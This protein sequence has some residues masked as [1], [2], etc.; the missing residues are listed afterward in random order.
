MRVS[1]SLFGWQNS[2]IYGSVISYNL[3]WL[4]VINYFLCLGHKERKGYWP[5]QKAHLQ[6]VEGASERDVVNESLVTRP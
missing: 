1:N 4:S 3:Y 5:L 6:D 2:A